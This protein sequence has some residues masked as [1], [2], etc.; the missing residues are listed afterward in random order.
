ME[1]KFER[2]KKML[3]KVVAVFLAVSMLLPNLGAS[4][5]STRTM[6]ADAETE[7]KTWYTS[8]ATDWENE[9]TPLG[10]GFIGAMVFG[11]VDSD[12]I[13]INEHTLWSGGPGANSEYDGGHSGD[14][15]SA[16]ATLQEVRELL[17][18]E[19]T[20]FTNN[21]SAYID[22]N[23]NIISNDYSN[24]SEIVSLIN[25]LK[26]EKY[27]FGSYQT[28]GNIFI[29]DPDFTDP[30]VEYATS[31]TEDDITSEVAANLF[32]GSTST[33]WY[34][35][36][37]RANYNITWP[38]SIT[39]NYAS[40]CTFN[41]YSISS[42]NDAEGRD[43]SEWR[44]YGSN[45][46]SNYTLID[47]RSGV[48][49]SSRYETQNFT[50]SSTYT[51]KYF[52]FE[53]VSS[54]EG[55]PP[56]ISEITLNNS[57]KSLAQ[58]SDYVRSLDLNT[59]MET[60]SYVENG[61][62]YTKEYFISN[63]DNVMV[64]RLTADKS[65]SIDRQIYVNSVQTNKTISVSGDTITMVGQPADQSADGIK[66]AQQIKVIPEN[67]TIQ[68]IYNGVR[69]SGADSV[70]IIMSCGTN[71]VQCMDDSFD[72]FSDEDPLTAV[73][74]R[75]TAAAS[76]G[77]D[78]LLADHLTDYKNL[79]NRV[80]ID[81][82]YTELPS[83]PTN[84]LLAGYN[85]YNTTAENRYLEMLYYQFGRY[86]L[87]ACSREGSLPANL[88]GIWADGLNPPW[89]ADYHTNVNLEMNYWPAE[90]CN[91]AECHTSV[92]DYI[93]SLVPRGTETAQYY[94]AAQ[95]GSTIRGWTTFHENNIWGNTGPAVSDAF[96]F[97][98]GAAWLCQDLWEYYQ[99]NMDEEFLAENFNTMLQ[100]ALFWVD[101]LW[102]D[103]RDGT[104]VSS[105]S[106]SPEHGA[107]SLGASCDQEI[108]WE[109]FNMVIEAA[110]ILNINTSEIQEIKTAQS[111]LYLPKIGLAGEYLEWKDETT[112]DITGDYGHR[113]VNH[114]FSL[115]PGTLVVAGRS[116]EDDKIVEAMK[117]V[118]EVR[119]DGGTGWSKAW[120]INMWARLRDGDHA[121][122]MVNQ[123]LLDSTLDN[124]FDTHAPFQIDGNFGATAGMTEMLLQ[125]QGDS[126][127]LLPALPTMWADGSVSGIKARGDFEVA[128]DWSD[129]K[130]N[131]ATVKSGSGED[132]TLSYDDISS[133]TI[134]TSK[135]A[136]VNYTVVDED[137]I[138]FATTEGETY[139][140]NSY[141][142][143]VD[144][145]N[146]YYVTYVDNGNTVATDAVVKGTN[147]TAFYQCEAVDGKLFAGWYTKE[148][149]LNSVSA[150][151][152]SQSYAAELSSI[153]N[154][155]TLY[156]GW[157]DMSATGN[158][159]ELA[160]AQM[161][162]AD[163]SGLR[164][165]TE[166]G[167]ELVAKV[168]ALNTENASLQPDSA[169]DKGIGFGTVATKA[170][171]VST[172]ELVK[173]VNAANVAK[174][175]AVC[176]AEKL[177]DVTEDSYIY[178]CVVTGIKSTRFTTDIAARP[179]ITY[180]DA[181]GT[182]QTYYYTEAAS[183][184]AGG[185]YKTNVYAVAKAIYALDST[186]SEM[187]D[188]LKT[189]VIDVVE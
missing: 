86:L 94:F 85:N 72:Y 30:L 68:Q 188:W 172:T 107:Y 175:M 54:R 53:I 118:L 145:D 186:S 182:E 113:H 22:G 38:P 44:L 12:K 78:S 36:N 43:P 120:K 141:P 4:N 39:W 170:S 147:P 125:S 166:I 117:T 126:V 128:M 143:D 180:M 27:N 100:A 154:D 60:V 119:G 7:L 116:E 163:P 6:A 28:V 104:L 133:A 18:A 52:R 55:L 1:Y 47:T 183:S 171:N 83:K 66:F 42:A 156:A 11:G 23:G 105:P 34:A 151:T 46:G 77:Y 50:L 33:K 59:A 64:I 160:G 25:E 79:F 138:T 62:K 40:P 101:N 135:G 109:L 76:K 148:V 92:I 73:S 97:P 121:G 164:F 3:R 150:I 174:G 2:G 142:A 80:D 31:S 5:W 149:A 127:D 89:D 26:G 82:G 74:Q 162:I 131:W 14:S 136:T 165:V 21:K 102:E 57:N 159:L 177:Y 24:S 124:L 137:T 29:D 176:P 122:V 49:F 41:N 134:V 69:V 61:V 115:H 56:Q 111:R 153:N 106:Y 35:G 139:Y 98:A 184:N 181:N 90:Q 51:Y 146:L 169:S 93:N 168:E 112:M 81:F 70:L 123:I 114:L 158:Q 108:I 155:T 58:Y 19:M 99:F 103:S 67:G 45:D 178:T 17:Q 48:T 189:N 65:G 96:Y 71:Y 140:V 84:E 9:A 95:D 32:D 75:V 63:P 187:K 20:D 132:C 179:Y 13:Q 37:C 144:P 91:L 161:R 167:I 16:K 185:G 87:I 130:L 157:I 152:A 8:P 173:D 15:D 88:Q 110:E 129:K 10:N